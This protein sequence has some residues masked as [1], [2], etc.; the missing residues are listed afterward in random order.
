[1]T[2]IKYT[3]RDGTE[4]KRKAPGKRTRKNLTEDIARHLECRRKQYMVWDKGVKGLHV[5][6]SPGGART[7]RSLWYYPGSAKPYTRKLDRV[8]VITLEKAR[9]LCLADQ[10]A[11]RE[12]TNPKR[13]APSRSDAFEAV[14]NEYIDREQIGRKHNATAE[15]ARRILL[16]DCAAFRYR[17]IASIRIDEIEDLLERIRDGDAE[18]RGRPYLA[19]K[20]WGLLGALFRWCLKKRKLTVSP[21]A[22]IDRPWEGAKSR[23]RVF[24]DDQL[25][26]LWTCQLDA[27][28]SA[29]LKLLIL[30]GKR[31]GALAAM[32]W[33]EINEAWDWT[34][35]GGNEI[36]RKHPLPL[37]RLAQRILI[38]LKPKGAQPDG[39]VFPALNWRFQRRVQKLTGIADFMPHACRH[40]VETK[41]AELKVP[42][43]VRDLLLD[44]ASSRGSGKGYDHWD[45]RE[46]KLEA[47]ELW[48]DYVERLVMPK[49]VKVLR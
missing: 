1:M 20:L 19:V 35:T 33:G 22:A 32:R 38:G 3:K 46:E 36:K 14:V 2:K 26:K 29:Y 16:K 10:K 8:G 5:M 27:G 45:Y 42:P 34:P 21:M 48:A 18:H 23:D 24:S 15:E 25:K 9:E 31:K 43:H 39:R 7:Y 49:G 44:H 11:A 6:V 40:T 28:E 13:D 47:I 4:A 17:S 41:L 37:P 30:T 12:G